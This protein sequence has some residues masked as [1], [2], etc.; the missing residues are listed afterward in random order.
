[1]PL[2]PVDGLRLEDSSQE[3]SVVAANLA[4]SD[5][6]SKFVVG[7]TENAFLVA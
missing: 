2:N 6:I 3:K 4:T 7:R 5:F 1:M